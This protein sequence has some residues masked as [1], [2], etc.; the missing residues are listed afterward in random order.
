MA[1]T[2]EQRHWWG[3]TKQCA[4]EDHDDGVSLIKV[5]TDNLLAVAAHLTEVEA[6]LA[7]LREALGEAKWVIGQLA[8]HEIMAMQ[9]RGWVHE[10]ADVER[11][12]RAMALIEAALAASGEQT[13][14]ERIAEGL[15]SAGDVRRLD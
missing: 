12:Q 15:M 10:P 7:A 4:R 8:P 11:G 6:R 1:L 14:S 2:E 3:W 5:D 13:P 9:V